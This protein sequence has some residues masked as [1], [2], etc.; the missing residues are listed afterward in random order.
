MSLLDRL[1][2]TFAGPLTPQDRPAWARA[3]T[4]EDLGEL[5]AQWLEGRIQ[6]QPGY[7]GPCDVDE[8]LAPG[9][10]DT[11]IALNRAGFLTNNSQ[12]G[13]A[14]YG[15][16]A[17][18]IGFASPAVA[19]RLARGLDGTEYRYTTL[20]ARRP[21]Q[22]ADGDPAAQFNWHASGRGISGMY[23]GLHRQALDALRDAKQLT[24]Y[25]PQIGRN[26]LWAA[27]S[28]ATRQ[29]EQETTTVPS[30]FDLTTEQQRLYDIVLTVA[31][32]D[33]ED[34][35]EVLRRCDG[36][37]EDKATVADLLGGKGAG[38]EFRAVP[39]DDRV[40][41]INL[42]RTIAVYE[43]EGYNLADPQAR[44]AGLRI[45]ADGD[46]EPRGYQDADHLR[47]LADRC[48]RG[49]DELTYEAEHAAEMLGE[50]GYGLD[51][52]E[53]AANKQAAAAAAREYAAGL[54]AEAD[55]LAEGQRPS[56]ERIAQAE[57][58]AAAAELGGILIDGRRAAAN[59]RTYSDA[60]RQANLDAAADKAAAVEGSGMFGHVAETIDGV[61]QV[62][63]WQLGAATSDS[64]DQSTHDQDTNTATGCADAEQPAP[65]GWNVGAYA[66]AG[67]T[68]TVDG[69]VNASQGAIS[70]ATG[71]GTGGRGTSGWADDAGP[72]GG[73]GFVAGVVADDSS[74]VNVGGQVTA[75]Q[76]N[77][78]GGSQAAPTRASGADDCDGF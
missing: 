29:P 19:E 49:A 68:V 40:K 61:E 77:H 13:S 59:A 11:L 30:Y 38:D 45:T 76:V 53:W 78:Y 36:S 3:R 43:D 56:E 44:D 14:E 48:E 23:F 5:T 15:Q 73:G 71:G 58:V 35:R 63:F 33:G 39:A 28:A 55:G 16:Q 37:P 4:L 7:Y 66:G 74:R 21:F 25:D 69:D 57:K 12:A 24:I 50:G 26:T 41:E 20:S 6:S 17:A 64:A 62:P 22:R 1:R 54:R 67:E 27:L 18:V 60:E 75:Q 65:S 52:K 34:T 46:N 9:L 8:E 47:H 51:P 70:G 42:A 32:E 2:E 31:G 72:T 10:T